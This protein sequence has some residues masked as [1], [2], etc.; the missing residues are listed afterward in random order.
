M[1][2][3]HISFQLVPDLDQG[4]GERNLSRRDFLESL[5]LGV[6]WYLA[7]GAFVTHSTSP[8]R[9]DETGVIAVVSV[10]IQLRLNASV[11]PTCKD[12]AADF[13]ISR[14]DD[15]EKIPEMKDGRMRLCQV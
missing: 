4:F 8:E 3:S 9:E 11:Y 10:S 12:A 15:V 6:V 1:K 14:P 5:F 13:V 7:L 2:I